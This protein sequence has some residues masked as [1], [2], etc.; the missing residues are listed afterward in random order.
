DSELFGHERGAFPDAPE[1]TS[2]LVEIAERGTLFL[3]EIAELPAELQPK[4]LK[5]LETRSFRRLGGN[6]EHTAD[7]RLIA[8]TSRNL[9]DE[10][11]AGRFREDLYYRLSVMPLTLPPVRDRA[12]D[13]RLALITRLVAGLR[14]DLPDAPSAVA[15]EAL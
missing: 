15:A 14:V 1:R 5:F 7:V 13:D 11:E 12:R 9:A 3:D 8:A 2:G 4:L 10:V 6:R